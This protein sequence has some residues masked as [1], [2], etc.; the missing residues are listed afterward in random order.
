MDIPDISAEELNIIMNLSV[1]YVVMGKS[2]LFMVPVYNI[3][4]NAEARA[5]LLERTAHAQHLAE[6]GLLTDVSNEPGFL[7]ARKAVL[8]KKKR[9]AKFYIVSEL[10]LAMYHSEDDKWD[11]EQKKEYTNKLIQRER[12]R[13]ED[14]RRSKEESK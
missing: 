1:R 7:E 13:V 5:R 11:D 3:E 6:V 4:D 12:D 10:G 14:E 2:T 8:E 9:D